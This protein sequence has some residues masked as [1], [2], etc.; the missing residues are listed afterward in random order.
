MTELDPPSRRARGWTLRRRL[1]LLFTGAA[2]LAVIALVVGI[3]AFGGLLDAREQIVEKID[4]AAVAERDLVAAI[5]DQET[6]VRGFTLTADETFLEPYERGLEAAAV[7]SERL[8]ELVTDFPDVTTSVDEALR[9]T[10]VW[11]ETFAEP[12]I[13]RVRLFGA[14]EASTEVLEAGRVS[15]EAIRT[16]F[17]VVEGEL[18]RARDD[19]LADL[20]RATTVLIGSLVGVIVI[21]L[22]V[23][24][25]AYVAFTRW[26]LRPLERL[27]AGSRQV[28]EGDLNHELT[29]EGPLEIA[30][31]GSDVEAMR[32]RIATEVAE[33]QAARAELDERALD[34]ARSNADLEQFA[35]V[36]SHDLQEPLRKVTS[37]CQLLQR[38]YA[39][40]LDE[41]A[42]QYIEFAV[43]GARRM[44]VLINDLLTFSRVGR[45]TD[46]FVAVDMHEIANRAAADL[47]DVLVAADGRVEVDADLPTVEGDPTLLLMLLRNLVGNAIKF[48]GDR[49]PV[50]A[51]GATRKDDTVWTFTVADN[52]IGIEPE[53]ADKV[54][55]IFQRL[56]PR[57]EY[58]GTGI[59]LALAKK[60]VEFH[61]GE[62]WI[63]TSRSDGTTI[64]FTIPE[65]RTTPARSTP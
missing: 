51:I 8:L 35:Y 37:F 19:G 5:I 6:G 54:F 41:R 17:D 58:D 50:V 23:G 21:V 52:G 61:G 44:Q 12:E 28:T 18:N 57:E 62:I 64:E 49:P 14:G 63:D 47:D 65:K 13:A 10:T 16:Q 56:H 40:Q 30:Q 2:V 39:G 11:Q 26:T 22:L 25:A 24:A 1:S 43:D 36:A 29:P 27:G 32:R 31:L 55:V 34:L 15:F 46:T 7:A 20:D 59:G 60:I 33:L 53:Y 45:N 9:L 48:R 42:D 4:P 38:R 3:M